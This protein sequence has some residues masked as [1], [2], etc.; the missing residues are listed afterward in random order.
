MKKL[1]NI[2]FFTYIGYQIASFFLYG[3]ANLVIIDPLVVGIIGGVLIANYWK[4]LY[5]WLKGADHD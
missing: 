4:V 5:R 1:I 3:A 2:I